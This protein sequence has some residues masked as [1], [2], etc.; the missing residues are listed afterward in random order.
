MSTFNMKNVL[1]VFGISY[2]KCLNLS[3][4]IEIQL[5]DLIKICDEGI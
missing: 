2:Y 1:K 4:S 3:N 5:I